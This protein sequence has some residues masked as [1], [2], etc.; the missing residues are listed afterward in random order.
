M[1]TG[2]VTVEMDTSLRD[3]QRIFAQ[4]AFHH[5]LVIDDHKLVGVISDRDL[6]KNLSPFL[7]HNFTERPQ[8]LATLDKRAH[9]IMSRKVV[10]V[11]PMTTLA[12]AIEHLLDHPVS[13][14]PVIDENQRPVGILTWRDILEHALGGT[15]SA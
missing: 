4:H 12:S 1:T 9:Q 3:V 2:I 15:R 11:T 8:D 14:L 5:L 7:G 6:L 10:S 13:C